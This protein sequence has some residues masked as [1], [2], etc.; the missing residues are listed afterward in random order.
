VNASIRSVRNIPNA[1]QHRTLWTAITAVSITMIG[2]LVVGLVWLLTRVIAFLQPILIPFA[3]AG[4]LAYLLEPMVDRLVAWRIKRQH[5]VMSVFVL[6]TAA[7][8]G[9]VLLV[10]PA[11]VKQGGEF[12]VTLFGTKAPT[13]AGTPS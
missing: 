10:V 13:C 1:F 6:A 4:V 3:V 5:A 9:I 11:L 7:I 8:V 12:A 2:A